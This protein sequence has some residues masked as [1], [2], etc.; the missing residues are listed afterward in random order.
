MNK[1]EAK[2]ARRGLWSLPSTEQ[3]PPWE[4][5]KGSRSIVIKK[6]PTE[7]NPEFECS[8]KR[9]CKEMV[10]CEEAMYYLKHCGL[11]RLDGD[12]DGVPCEALFN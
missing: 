11:S 9:Y 5:R 10:S 3:V 6:E 12:G 2:E 1:Q 7:Y 8:I 4:W